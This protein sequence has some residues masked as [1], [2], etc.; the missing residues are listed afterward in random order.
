MAAATMAGLEAHTMEDK[1]IQYFSSI[2][3]MASKIMQEREKIK[4]KHGSMWDKMSPQEQDSAIDNS[5]M[6]PHIQSRY[7]MHSVHR[8][9][10]VCYPKLLMQTGQKIVH[11]GEEDITWQDEHSAP[12]S[13]ETKSQLE[14]SLTSG[15]AD[16][17]VSVSQGD[18]KTAKNP[19]SSQIGKCTA[20]TKVSVSESR[21]PEEESAFWKISAERSRLEGEQADF[22]SLTPSQIKS[23]EKGEKP[24]PSY[25]RQET[26]FPSK[27][28]EAMADPHPPAPS[29]AT[30]QRAPKP[31]APHP[32]AIVSAPA[33]VSATP[34]SISISPSPAP[35]VSVLSSVAGWERSQS[36]LPVVGYTVDEVYPSNILSKSPTLSS[37]VEKE[38]EPSPG[39]PAFSQFNSSNNMMKTG[40]DFLDNW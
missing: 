35:P 6:D 9:E 14:F 37:S 20:G 10:V 16:Q 23:L 15:T 36:T 4:S 33:V 13:W 7:A 30:K 1:K 12:F 21:R 18:S 38:K 5:I 40:F 26:C 34:A 24:L 19:H 2:N 39:S 22:Q 25:L 8:E 17:A 3:S 27:E 32:P 28:Q 31:P 11:F 29:R